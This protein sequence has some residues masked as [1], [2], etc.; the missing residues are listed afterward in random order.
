[1]SQAH[2]PSYA[3]A[4]AGIFGNA[5]QPSEKPDTAFLLEQPG[6]GV[7]IEPDGRWGLRLTA[8]NPKAGQLL[9]LVL[10][11]LS[12]LSAQTDNTLTLRISA[13]DE[14]A[15]KDAHLAEEICQALLQLDNLA[16]RIT[17]RGYDEIAEP[18][19]RRPLLMQLAHV[20]LF[21]RLGVGHS[22]YAAV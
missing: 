9:L 5:I 1:M 16:R 19:L 18:A 11:D 2:P 21:Q 15:A 10:R 13:Y 3:T 22:A 20:S 14:A 4:F 6:G 17:N 7:L 8:L 12:P